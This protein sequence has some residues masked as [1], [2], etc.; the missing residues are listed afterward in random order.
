L[1]DAVT[2]E[3]I[4]NCSVRATTAM[5]ASAVT[6]GADGAFEF[7]GIGDGSYFVMIQCP[8]HLTTCLKPGD[9][10]SVPCGAITLFKD[11]QRSDFN[12][13]LTPGAVVRGRVLNS[14]GRPLPK[15]T[16]RL[17]GP[18]NDR[19]VAIPP[20]ATTGAD[21]RFEL[22]KLPDG[23]WR[24]E[25]DVPALPGAPRPPV[26]YYPGV[27]AREQAGFVELVAGRVR[28]NVTITVPSIL[29]S[30]ITVRMP[31]PDET[32]TSVAVSMIRA[33]PLM[34]L[35]LNLDADGQAVVRGLVEGRYFLTATAL[36]EQRRWVAYQALDF[37]QD[38]IE[39]SLH[40]QPAGRIRGRIVTD[41]GS[42]PLL[43]DA[44]VGALWVDE[45]V[46]L[47]PLTPD[48]SPVAADGTFEID[49]VFGRRLIQLLRFDPSWRI[50]SV[51]SGRT[52]VTAAGVEV[53]L[54]STTELTIMVRPR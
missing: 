17:G 31:P 5:R 36:Q 16:V 52:D 30:T 20:P 1:T 13:R 23:E 37:V 26:I 6:T 3:P 21:G 8:S 15:A 2:N 29:D 54:N 7:A 22:G 19:P 48:E 18:F 39:I 4:A 51:I 25:V 28:E 49:G 47:N 42:L 9:P 43:S 35:P 11:Q 50:H 38:S 12:Y 45:G 34:T 10:S 40:L 46:T 32:M 24:L 27:L 14:A 44:T 33:A 41:R 53:P